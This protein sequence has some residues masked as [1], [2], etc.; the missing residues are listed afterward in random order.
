MMRSDWAESLCILQV[1]GVDHFDRPMVVA[2]RLRGDQRAGAPGKLVLVALGR[3]C[4]SPQA[5]GAEANDILAVAVVKS[6]RRDRSAVAVE[7]CGEGRIY[8]SGVAVGAVERQL[9]NAPTF[10]RGVAV[11]GCFAASE[12]E[13]G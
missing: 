10:N 6:G 11:F 12:D 8:V 5:R 9:E 7:L 2:R 13:Q 3:K 1:E 4:P